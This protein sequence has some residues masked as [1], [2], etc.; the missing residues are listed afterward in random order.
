MDL[1]RIDR[2]KC[3]RCGHCAEVCP[4]GVI[5]MDEQGPK[6]VKPFC[7]SCGHCVAV[8]PFDALD[9]AKAPLAHQIP[10]EKMPV[11]DGNTAASFPPQPGVRPGISGDTGSP[12]KNPAALDIARFAQTS[13][14]SQGIAFKVIDDRDTLRRIT[15]VTVDW[16]EEAL[17]V[18]P[19][20]G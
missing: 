10:L 18:P 16:V 17:K 13:G 9:N 6:V 11:I 2:D 14:N 1:L 4:T 15:A 20:A 7:L 12:G 8:C 19:F 5:G 3:T